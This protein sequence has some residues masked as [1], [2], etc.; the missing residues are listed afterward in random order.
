MT[1]ATTIE[2]SGPAIRAALAEISPDECA[3]FEAE[4]GAA[5]ERAR[6]ELDLMPAEEVLDRWWGITAIRANPLS[7]AER[8]QLARAH[9]GDFAGLWERDEAGNWVQL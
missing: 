9:S 1:T 8:E 5:L 3:Q 4:L 6:A 7:A 2:R